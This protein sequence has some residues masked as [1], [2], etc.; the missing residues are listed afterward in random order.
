[1][2]PDRIRDYIKTHLENVKSI[3]EVDLADGYGQVPLPYAFDRKSRSA[4]ADWLWQ[5]VFPSSMRTVNT[6]TGEMTRFHMSP[7]TVEKAVKAAATDVGVGKRVTC[8]TLKAQLRDASVGVWVRYSHRTGTARS[9]GHP[10]YY[11]LYA[12]S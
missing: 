1:M 3:H 9:Q 10:D 4:A 6:E 12:R 2:L 11:D 8:H 5:Y 7:S